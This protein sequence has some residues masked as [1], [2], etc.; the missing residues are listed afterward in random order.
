M[1]PAAQ[2]PMV[3]PEGGTATACRLRAKPRP[4]S[5]CRSPTSRAIARRFPETH[6]RSPGLPGGLALH[7]TQPACSPMRSKTLPALEV[8]AQRPASVCRRVCKEGHRPAGSCAAALSLRRRAGDLGPWPIGARASAHGARSAGWPRSGGSEEALH[9]LTTARAGGRSSA[10]RRCSPASAPRAA[11]HGETP[12]HLLRRF[13]ER[14]RLV[15]PRSTGPPDPIRTTHPVVA[16]SF[17]PKRPITTGGRLASQ[18]HPPNNTKTRVLWT[19]AWG[20]RSSP[21]GCRTSWAVTGRDV[22]S[23]APG[24]SPQRASRVPGFTAA[25]GL[26]RSPTLSGRAARAAE[27]LDQVAMDL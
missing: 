16:P 2:D 1:A 8:Q 23:C 24:T 21:T 12:D 22:R 18:S 3:G 13:S 6:H 17:E 26:V 9:Q 10:R 25:R 11:Q 20:G 14:W 5:P 19:R 7:A 27:R 15:Q 4:G